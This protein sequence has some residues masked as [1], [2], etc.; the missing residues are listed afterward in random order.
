VAKWITSGQAFVQVSLGFV[1]AAILV[2]AFRHWHVSPGSWASGWFGRRFARSTAIAKLA[3][4]TAD[5]LE[6]GLDRSSALSVAAF[7]NRAPSL[8]RAAQRLAEGLRTQANIDSLDTR[9][10][11]ATIAHALATEMPTTSRVR[12]LREIGDCYA[13]RTGRVLSWSRG[14][15]APLAT[16]AIGLIVG[17]MVI[18]LMAPLVSLVENLSSAR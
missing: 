3:V 17:L 7:A 6:A 16:I 4:F 15:A 18:G 5:L 2:I 13:D 12:V 11:S 8:R 14:M 10:M 1:V 9:H